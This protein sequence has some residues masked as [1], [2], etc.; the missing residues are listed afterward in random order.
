MEK[1]NKKLVIR[2]AKDMGINLVAA[3]LIG[4][5][6]NNVAKPNYFPMSGV[7]GIM[8]LLNYFF[9]TPLGV[10]SLLV[11]IPI[12]AVCWR[13]LSR[14]FVLKSIATLLTIA[15]VV[16][17]LCPLFP[18]FTGDRMLAA[19]LGGT[20]NGIGAAFIFANNSSGGGI[21]FITMSIKSRRP[22]FSVGAIGFVVAAVIITI[23]GI[24]YHDFTGIIYGAI[25]S[26]I[27]SLIMDKILYRM[28]EGKLMLIISENNDLISEMINMKEDRSSTL[29][30]AT[31]TFTGREHDILMCACSNREMYEIREAIND[32]DDKAFTII[33]NSREVVG[34]GFLKK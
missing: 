11:N 12:I 19:V 21:D 3:L 32:L 25:L 26:F 15:I 9:G 33:L 5:S 30:N 22:Y 18:V 13:F 23:S 14:K 27:S 2:S 31:G 16:D 6:I 4:L 20:L 10:I 28:N 24:C 17:K 34:K 29:I 8:L 7:S 1:I